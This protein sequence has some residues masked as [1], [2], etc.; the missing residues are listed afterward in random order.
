MTSIQ[1]QQGKHLHFVEEE[2][3]PDAGVPDDA[4]LHLSILPL[5]SKVQQPLLKGGVGSTL[6]LQETRGPL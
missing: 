4:L 5:H 3:V 1:N 6:D 2:P